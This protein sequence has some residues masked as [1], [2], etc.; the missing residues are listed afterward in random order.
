MAP[1][2]MC[3]P[4]RTFQCSIPVEKV[5]VIPELIV[6]LCIR[7]LKGPLSKPHHGQLRPDPPQR[8][9]GQCTLA[10]GTSSRTHPSS[11]SCSHKWN[12]RTRSIP[13]NTSIYVLESASPVV[14]GC[15]LF[16]GPCDNLGMSV[17]KATRGISVARISELQTILAGLRQT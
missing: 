5:C 13:G 1:T 3:G 17:R 4:S 11:A 9:H 14:L 12:H 2:I 6:Q 16:R 7:V 10:A 15:S 8:S